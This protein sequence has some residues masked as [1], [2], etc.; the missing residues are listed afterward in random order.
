MSNEEASKR[1]LF[2]YDESAHSKVAVQR[3]VTHH[4]TNHD[5]LYIL[6]VHPEI[7]GI[8]QLASDKNKFEKSYT[9][10]LKI[11]KSMAD[12]IEAN[13]NVKAFPL[14]KFGE[15][16]ETIKNCV[17]ELKITNLIMGSRGLGRLKGILL[18]SVSAYCVKHCPC[19]V[20]I[21]KDKPL[22]Q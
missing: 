11:I 16:R 3:M 22:A 4:L 15:P 8:S 6:F 1:I 18:G 19:S 10:K 2:A 17:E 21:I 9:S 13:C 12:I 7:G 14:I 20:T 5:E